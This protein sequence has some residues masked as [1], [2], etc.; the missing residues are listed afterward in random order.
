MPPSDPPAT[1]VDAQRELQA[2]RRHVA[3]S[4]FVEA[5][6]AYGRVLALQP[7]EAES[8]H[9]LGAAAAQRGDYDIAVNLLSRSSK[10]APAN[11]NVLT[12]LGIVYRRA[13]RYDAARYTLERA[14]RLGAARNP[15]IRLVL[16]HLLETDRRPE[17]ALLH[18]CQATI[19][20]RQL[21][22]W[23]GDDGVGYETDRLV[24][25]AAQFIAT[26][27]RAWFDRALASAREVEDANHSDR[28]DDAV[29]MHLGE[30]RF[31]LADPRQRAGFMHVPGLRAIA[32]PEPS[33]FAW[34]AQVV[35]LVALEDEV[36]ACLAK[37][38][39]S[40]TLL[41]PLHV[42]GLVQYEAR[43]HAPRLRALVE[44]LPLANVPNLAPDVSLIAIDAG[45]RLPLHHGPS[46]ARCQVVVNLEDGAAIEVVVGGESRTLAPGKCIAIDPSL[47]VEYRNAGATRAKL[48]VLDAW[49]PDLSD[50]ERRA[51]SAV[52]VAALDFDARLQELN[53]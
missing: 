8:L 39:A 46:N 3:A 50:A 4:R 27:R 38:A 11:F 35:N 45:G 47:G 49:H 31:A 10:A 28:I 12:E 51:L 43:R 52:L 18:Y 40:G 1:H 29:A 53:A 30:R 42:R 32:F 44:A 7:E 17:L 25:H 14:T 5:E 37:A 36:N 48:L 26:G 33:A 34:L 6:Q 9:F 41:L 19:E 21:R 16:A 23:Q 20:A 13:E 22:R 15:S 2:A 24:P